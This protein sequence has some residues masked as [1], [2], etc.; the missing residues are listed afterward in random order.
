[1]HFEWDPRKAQENVQK[2]DVT[3]EEAAETF[4]DE[5]ALCLEDPHNPGRT[6]LIG[7]ARTPRLLFTVYVLREEGD[8]I[9]II[10]ARKATRKERKT[11]E[12]GEF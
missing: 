8:V 4:A 10:S 6:I 11:Y 12:E 2:H 3:F 7:A 9:R 1:V 5:H